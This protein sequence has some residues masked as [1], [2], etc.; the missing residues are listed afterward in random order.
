MIFSAKLLLTY[1]Q[2]CQSL[3]PLLPHL[4]ALILLVLLSVCLL[5]NLRFT[6]VVCSRTSQLL[7]QFPRVSVLVPARNEAATI[8]ACVI[9]LLRQEYP[10]MEVLVFDDGSTDGTSQQLDA[11]K[12]Q[13]PHLNVLHAYDDPP[14]GWNGKSYACHQLAEKA[15]GEWLLFTD[16]DTVH[17]SR[18]VEQGIVQAVALNAALVSAFPYQQTITWS[19]RILVSF[20]IDFLPLIGL[21]FRAIWLGRSKRVVANGQYLL[22]HASSYR[23]VGGHASI[24]CSL[25]DDFAL[26]QRFRACGQTVA[27]VDGA[28][29]LKCRMYH[30]LRE[31]W[32]GFTKNLLLALSSSSPGMSSVGGAALFAWCYVCLFVFPFFNLAFSEQWA[33]AL[34][35]IGWLLLLRALVVWQLRRPFG[36][37]LT[38]PLAA[39][40]VLALGLSALYR[41]FHGKHVVWKG[42]LYETTRTHSTSGNFSSSAMP[43]NAYDRARTSTSAPGRGSSVARMRGRILLPRKR[44]S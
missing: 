8:G 16:A 2:D 22:A 25:I 34:L 43:Y 9:S 44:N 21:N 40:S 29:L 15:T 26:A 24:S 6:R 39:W 33:L 38:T 13:F 1:L 35:E 14:P 41:R 28:Q 18:S 3:L 32:N 5:S 27:L 10:D 42:R 36:E 30:S 4:V 23:A 19:E 17:A 12:A 37:I 20:I 11:L 7:K 31:V